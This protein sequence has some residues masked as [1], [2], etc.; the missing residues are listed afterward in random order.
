MRACK[1]I[2]FSEKTEEKEFIFAKIFK[3]AEQFLMEN[4]ER[5]KG[6]LALSPLIVFLLIYLVSS[7]IAKD[8]YKI[9]IASA[10]LIASAYALIISKKAP[11]EDKIAI[12]SQG[13]GH[14]NVLLMLWIFI[15]A[16]A[17][18]ET[19][20][21]IGAIDATVSATLNILPP[22]M[23]FVGLFIASCF[24]SMAIGTSVGTIV[25]LVP[26]AA[27]I[28]SES[29]L[30]VGFI[31]AIV[32]GGAFFGDNLSFI[33]DTTI[34][35]TKTQ[36]C[37]MSDKFKVNLKIVAPAAIAVAL[38]YIIMGHNAAF[39]QPEDHINWVRL[40][41]YVLVIGL[42]MSGIN[43]V[44]VLA[45]GIATNAVIGFTQG[46]LTWAGWLG[47]IGKGIAS[48]G[49]LIIVTMLSGGMLEIIRYNGG[50]DYLVQILTRRISGKRGAELSIAT[51]VSLANVC[52]ANNTIAILTTG[53]IAKGIT[54]RFKLD[55]RKTASILDT[56]SC[57]IQGLLP[58]GAQ[59][60]MAS[61]L[62]G[63][64]SLSIIKY[65]FYPYTMGIFAL[66]A[67]LFRYPKQYS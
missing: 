58:Y 21:E 20:R 26:V 48:M 25:A 4:I 33:S 65:L 2:I 46:T 28:A 47:S 3:T 13:A 31:T 1:I 30:D 17:F 22:S 56:F 35:A 57:M 18:A 8:F 12:F 51:L 41:P 53:R 37:L 66:L 19:A 7:I 5:K 50:I 62:A 43:V 14:K 38:I 23:L 49:D 54:E 32:A 60:L 27:G 61:G 6:L 44:E 36:G 16:G 39:T 9:P 34:A 40:I 67:I 24:I 64:S 63:I 55:P 11:I 59:M 52:T 29:G 10:F 15:L 42:A 45:I